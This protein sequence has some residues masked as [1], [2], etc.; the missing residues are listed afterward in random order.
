MKSNCLYCDKETKWGNLCDT[1]FAIVWENEPLFS[2]GD[3]VLHPWEPQYRPKRMNM[4]C[5][6]IAI[7]PEPGRG[8]FV[9]ASL[10]KDG[11]PSKNQKRW[12]YFHIDQL[13]R[14]APHKK[15]PKVYTCPD[16]QTAGYTIVEAPLDVGL[17]C[18]MCGR[19]YI[20]QNGEPD[21]LP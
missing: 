7:N 15:Y 9:L 8:Y 12:Q 1:H 18:V 20:I 4:V 17:K 5:V 21:L 6:I 3:V 16:C 19:E 2:V 13:E 14:C 10:K 11:T